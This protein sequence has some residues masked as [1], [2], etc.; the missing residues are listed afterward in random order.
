[1]IIERIIFNVAAFAIF[2]IIFFK[3]IHRNDTSY[4]YVLAIQALGIAISFIGL[5][6]RINLPII[7]IIFIYIISI[8]LPLAIIIFERKGIFL[9]EIICINMAKFYYNRNDSEKAK[10]ILMKMLEKYPNSYYIHRQLAYI[11]EKN[12]DIDIAIDEY[13]RASEINILDY[14]L[15]LKVANL[16]N[17]TTRSKEA[18][19]V[20]NDLLRA[21]PDYYEASCLLGDILYG[22][23]N[24]KEAVNVYLQALNYNPDKYELYYNLGMAY[25]RLNDFQSAKEY[26]EKAAELNSLL[27]HAKYDLGQIALL[28]NELEEAEDYFTE[29]INDEELAD[30]VYYYL[31]YIAM[32]KGD[33][34]KAIQYLNIAV[35]ENEEIYIKASKELIFKIIINQIRKP[36]NTA[37]N[38][39]KITLKELETIKHLEETCAVVGNLSQNDIKAIRLLRKKQEDRERE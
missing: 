29:C 27:Y 18:V 35:E 4:T 30:E 39:K 1:M 3:M 16:L 14:N 17:T 34:Q 32:L 19:R 20:L 28:Y 38:K 36:T 5:I 2:L 6:F 31:A 33:K 8:L 24:Y 9:S 11:C 21:K 10:E 7:I 37:K 12:G 25:T 23:E 26:Y 15:K 22:Q 13:M